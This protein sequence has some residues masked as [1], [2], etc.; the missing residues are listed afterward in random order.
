[1][2]NKTAL[3]DFLEQIVL[4]QVQGTVYLIPAIMDIQRDESLEKEKQQ[5]IDAYKKGYEQRIVDQL[6]GALDGSPVGSH[7]KEEKV[8]ELAN[9]YASKHYA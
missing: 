4:K 9:A 3:Q 7:Y 2:T 8:N 6:Q 5:M 1:M